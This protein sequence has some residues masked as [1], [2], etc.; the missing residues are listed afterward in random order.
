MPN[1]VNLSREDYIKD[2][3]LSYLT[4][5][6]GWST[7][8]LITEKTKKEFESTN[9]EEKELELTLNKL[10]KE[11]SIYIVGHSTLGSIYKKVPKET[12]TL[13]DCKINHQ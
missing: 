11:C 8:G 7:L 5:V 2:V 4:T 10:W 12:P 1:V 9:L 3:I 13:E 6:R